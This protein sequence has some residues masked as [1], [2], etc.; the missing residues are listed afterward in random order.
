MR[1]L[2]GSIHDVERRGQPTIFVANKTEQNV[3][4]IDINLPSSGKSFVILVI[5]PSF[6]T[7]QQ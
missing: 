2:V 4:N 6:R 1:E 7:I 5:P 3:I